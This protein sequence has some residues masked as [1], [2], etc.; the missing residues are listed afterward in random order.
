MAR[1]C[2][3]C[4]A[5]CERHAQSGGHISHAHNITKRKFKINLQSVKVKIDGKVKKMLVC[6]KCLRSGK[7][8]KAY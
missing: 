1:K 7:V 2:A 3:I 5:I 4:E 6:T 8:N